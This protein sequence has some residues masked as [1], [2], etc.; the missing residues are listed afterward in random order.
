MSDDIDK[1]GLL[2]HDSARLM[3]KRFDARA[4]AYGLSSAQWR[5]LVRVA[6]E[7]GIA[8]ARIAELLE[9]EPISVSRLV[10]RMEDGGWIERRSDP[11]DRR[12]RQLYPTEKSMT[13]FG[14]IK[15]VAGEVFEEALTGLDREARLALIHGLKALVDNLSDGEP[16]AASTTDKAA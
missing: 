1:L 14:A 5:L 9:I 11:A 4:S 7:P 15:S 12:V 13:A 6:K 8:Q 16:A 10:D 3:R 2:I